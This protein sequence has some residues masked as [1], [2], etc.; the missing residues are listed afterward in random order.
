MNYIP[1]NI[2][3]HYELLSSLIK[4]EDLIT[5]AKTN[6]ITALG[7]TD[8]N[9]FSCM[10]FFNACKTNNIKPII[11]VKFEIENLNMTLYA[12]NYNGYINLLNLVS[13]R[14]TSTLTKE[15]ITKHS[16]NLICVTTDYEHHINY[17]EIYDKVYLSY[18]NEEEKKHALII[19][20]KI[21][22]SKETFYIDQ[23][24]EENLI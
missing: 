2:K 9:M 19:T 13:I 4:I 1:I 24:E 8:S 18:E 23:N 6:N 22:Y 21:V 7:I 17:I 14:N 20:D 16:N 12:E 10:D 5:F 11:G 3:T 15:E